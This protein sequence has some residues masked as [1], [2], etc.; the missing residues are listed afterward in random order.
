MV[1]VSLILLA[2]VNS[3]LEP[4]RMIIS[5]SAKEE[6]I[7]MH[8]VVAL[9]VPDGWRGV[10]GLPGGDGLWELTRLHDVVAL[11]VPGGWRG[12]RGLPGGDR[13]CELTR[14]HDVVA[15]LVPGGWRG[16]RG[17]PGGY[18]SA[19]HLHKSEG[20]ARGLGRGAYHGFR[21]NYQGRRGETLY[22]SA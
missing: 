2:S 16:V 10:R 20:G 5:Q 22:F 13:L 12:V 14:L 17:L 8:D 11:L 19:E 21:P 6:L 15:L 4:A 18:G 3:P 1:N 7:C 9:L